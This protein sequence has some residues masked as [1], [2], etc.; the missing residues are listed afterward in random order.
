[1]ADL[2]DT[3]TTIPGSAARPCG[4]VAGGRVAE[5]PE[6]QRRAGADGEGGAGDGDYFLWRTGKG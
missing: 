6:E 1:M 2:I 4:Q 5:L 3:S